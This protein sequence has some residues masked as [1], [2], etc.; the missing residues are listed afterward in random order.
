LTNSK[1]K[2]IHGLEKEGE[3]KRSCLNYEKAKKELGWKPKI[4]FEEGFEKTVN[5]FKSEYSSS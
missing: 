2:E 5:W 4:S 1:C 3:Q